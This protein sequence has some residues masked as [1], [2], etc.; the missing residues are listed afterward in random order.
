M[1][2]CRH[3][4]MIPF[5]RKYRGPYKENQQ[6]SEIS[7]R[8]WTSGCAF[9]ASLGRGL[10]A[11]FISCASRG[12]CLSVRP[13][14]EA[15]CCFNP[16]LHSPRGSTQTLAVHDFFF[17]PTF[18]LSFSLHFFSRTGYHSLSMGSSYVR[19][20]GSPVSPVRFWH[21]RATAGPLGTSPQPQHC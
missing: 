8:L 18:S 9:R 11:G 7:L 10:V 13:T 2:E 21:T 4:P 6:D 1:V 19:D 20:P 17:A 16:K 15:Q 5:W 3:P 14:A 12:V